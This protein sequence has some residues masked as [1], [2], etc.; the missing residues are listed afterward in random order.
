MLKNGIERSKDILREI[1]LDCKNNSNEATIQHHV[2]SLCKTLFPD[3]EPK[4]E[5]RTSK[6]TV[7]IYCR[8]TVIETKRPGIVRAATRRKRRSSESPKG[9]ALRYLD[10]IYDEN[11]QSGLKACVTDGRHWKF[12]DYENKSGKG[13]LKTHVGGGEFVLDSSNIN[14]FLEFLIRYIKGDSKPPPPQESSWIKSFE[15]EVVELARKFSDH[16]EFIVKIQLWEQLLQGS[17]ITISEGTDHKDKVNLFARHTL[18]IAVSKIITESL[19]PQKAASYN[20]KQCRIAGEGFHGWLIDAAGSSG[21]KFL[22]KLITKVELYEWRSPNRDVLKNL[23]QYVIPKNIRHDFGEYYTPDWLARAMCEEVLTEEIQDNLIDEYYCKK[24]PI[25]LDPSCG[26]GTFLYHACVLLLKAARR[27]NKLKNDIQAQ[28]KAVSS[29]V[30]GLDIHPVAVELAKATMLTALPATPKNINVYLGDSLQWDAKIDQVEQRSSLVYMP[31]GDKKNPEIMLP[32]R[33]I[34]SEGFNEI[35]EETFRIIS[36]KE[37]N[38][39]D[40]VRLWGANTNDVITAVKN[41]S[42]FLNRVIT[43]K[44]NHVWKSYI[45]NLS[46]PYKLKNKI[47]YMIGNPPWVVYNA[48]S[49]S[50][51]RQQKFKEE[52]ERLNLWVGRESATQ[53][54][55][56]ATFVA[57]CVIH[58][59]TKRPNMKNSFGFVLPYAVLKTN[60]WEKFR[61]CSWKFHDKSIKSKKTEMKLIKNVVINSAWDLKEIKKI[62]FN[63]TSAVIFGRK[64]LETETN[65]TVTDKTRSV[66]KNIKKV[67]MLNNETISEHEAWRVAKTKFKFVEAVKI[68]IDASDSHYGLRFR[69]GATLFPN[70]LCVADKAKKIQKNTYSIT[71]GKSKGVWKDVKPYKDEEIE[72]EHMHDVIFPSNIVPFALVGNEHLIAPR[73]NEKFEN[74]MDSLEKFRIFW[75]KVERVYRDTKTKKSPDTLIDQIDYMSKLT[76]QMKKSKELKIAYISSGAVMKAAV[77]PKG[78]YVSHQLFYYSS[79]NQ[80]ELD[81]LCAIFNAPK[82][83]RF[84]N[85]HCRRSDRDFLSAPPR[86]LPIKKYSGKTEHKDLA[87]LGKKARVEVTEFIQKHRISNKT[88]QSLDKECRLSIKSTLDEIDALVEIL[89]KDYTQDTIQV[90]PSNRIKKRKKTAS[91]LK[92]LS[93]F[94]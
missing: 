15:E 76:E 69:N 17:Y 50:P 14:D 57:T 63:T 45:T 85:E 21:K 91:E 59:L 74:P 66:I 83:S 35:V 54:D 81:Y 60:H 94:G 89:F 37:Y 9:Q 39:N 48:M 73:F 61:E 13:S 34:M 31:T 42:K 26:S 44:K 3:P 82:L 30:R 38:P 7:D 68:K 23:Y 46:Q 67:K 4:L 2:F 33:K 12:Y 24:E 1:L 71:T 20:E 10:A 29:I 47:N 79:K 28:T 49:G 32:I 36:K 65:V 55:L 53:N 72:E 93:T 90:Y 70:V 64:I 88:S 58:Y 52:A 92:E 40:V 5:L 86:N 80:E 62:P 78:M 27:H 84:F 56:A 77:I 87:N 22:K 41:T 16:T 18:L 51:E 6:G 25:V 43:E 19:Q 8:K 75:Q 11:P